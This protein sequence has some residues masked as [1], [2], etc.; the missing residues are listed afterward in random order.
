MKKTKNIKRILVANRSEVAMRIIRT[1]LEMDIETVSLFS[2]DDQDLPHA[3]EAHYSYCLGEGKLSD[4]YLNQDLILEVAKKFN[5]CAIHPGY[6]LLSENATFCEKVTKAGMIFIGPRSETIKMMGEKLRP[7]IQ[8]ASIGIPVIP[9]Y[10]GEDQSEDLLKK[11]AKEIGFPILI[12][13]SFG[14]GGKGIRIV[15]EE[16]DFQDSLMSVKREAEA[17]FGNGEVLIEKFIE[18]PRHIEVQVL[19]DS[20]GNHFHLFERECSIQRR[21]QKIIE[22]APSCFLD[23]KLRKKLCDTAIKITKHINYLGAGTIEFIFDQ[24]GNFYFLEMNTRLQVEH[25][26]TEMIT[27]LDIVKCQVQVAQGEKISWSQKDIYKNGHA[28]EVRIYAEDP[29]RDFLPSTGKILELKLPQFPMTRY[30]SGQ[31]AGNMITINYD[32]MILKVVT[33]GQ[34]R[35]VAIKKMIEVLKSLC[36]MGPTTN[37]SYLVKILEHTE[38]QKGHLSTHFLE[39]FKDDFKNDEKPSAEIL[40]QLLAAKHLFTGGTKGMSVGQEGSEGKSYDVWNEIGPWRV[41]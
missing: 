13:A 20:H 22:E 24:K 10:Q 30:D 41:S 33:W 40:A 36:L 15:H 17:S 35:L 28:L 1:C 3:K 37:I 7:K 27:G 23:E 25:A 11:K 9:G 14:G 31:V 4:T 19:S 21:Y 39:Y 34:E 2:T 12:K 16:K 38:F 26:V 18:S 32:P 5:V 6:G 8:L 29:Y